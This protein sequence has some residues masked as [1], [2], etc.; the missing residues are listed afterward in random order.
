MT[1]TARLAVPSEIDRAV[2]LVHAMFDELGRPVRDDWPDEAATAVRDRLGFDVVV[3]VA[4]GEPGSAVNSFEAI[5]VGVLQRRLPAASRVM[6]DVGYL[7][8][9]YVAP[10]HRR[11]GLGHAV[12]KATVDWLFDHGA[13][14]VD[15]HA[16]DRAVGLYESVGF[17]PSPSGMRTTAKRAGRAPYEG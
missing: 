12:V 3:M 10:A 5:A 16:S 7:E 6:P 11:R 17:R 2:R 8:W 4:D 14:V 15:L 13:A 1:P 9:T